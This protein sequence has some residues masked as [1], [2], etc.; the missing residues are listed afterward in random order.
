MQALARERLGYE[1][2]LLDNMVMEQT[3]TLK[4]AKQ[5]FSEL[6]E[7]LWKATD[8]TEPGSPPRRQLLP[9]IREGIVQLPEVAAATRNALS[10]LMPTFDGR[11][12]WSMETADDTVWEFASRLSICSKENRKSE[13][14]AA[15]KDAM[16]LL[17]HTMSEW[18][19][20]VLVFGIE[21]A[22][23]G[24]T[25]G[26]VQFVEENLDELETG[27]RG[28]GNFPKGRLVFARVEV[29]AI[30]ERSATEKA[31][32]LVDEHL[33]I[34]NAIC[35]SEIPSM[36]RVVRGDPTYMFYRWS[37]TSHSASDASPLR[38]FG[39]N[40]RMPLF[41]AAFEELMKRA[42]DA[43]I[44]QMLA[45]P[46]TEFNQRVLQAYQL[47]GAACV[48]RHP[49]RSFL[50]LAVALESAVLGRD[51]TSELTYQLGT[52]V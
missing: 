32:Q 16:T 23:A 52:R 15:L 4:K 25:F 51:T 10:E 26:K 34:L 43:K 38:V 28:G 37:R 49:E 31:E 18:T 41:R 13:L 7:T 50:M 2:G 14:R 40:L 17:F 19:V 42:L 6:A 33:M 27:D 29:T 36:I 12:E 22:C 11:S 46:G 44:S 47:A 3:V 30:D 5:I 35:S 48:D 39:Q 45:T 20:K 8:S 24:M 1:V 21:V 9:V